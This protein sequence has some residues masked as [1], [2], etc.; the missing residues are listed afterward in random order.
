MLAEA[1][2]RSAPIGVSELDV[3][4]RTFNT[5]RLFIEHSDQFARARQKPRPFPS[6]PFGGS[7]GVVFR[8]K[9][10]EPTSSSAK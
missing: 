1:A 3:T 8:S 4:Q 2:E 7:L 6:V 5:R 10:T 9:V